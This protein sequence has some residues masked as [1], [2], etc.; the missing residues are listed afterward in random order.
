V[1]ELVRFSLPGGEK[2]VIAE[3][4]N[5]V[6]SP[7]EFSADNHWMT[8][9]RVDLSPRAGGRTI[10]LRRRQDH[11]VEW[12]AT[13]KND[14]LNWSVFDPFSRLMVLVDRA[15]VVYLFDLQA[16]KQVKAFNL[17]KNSIPWYPQFSPGGNRFAMISE[18]DD[19]I[20]V[21]GDDPNSY[22][23]SILWL[24]DLSKPTQPER[25][26]LPRNRAIRFLWTPDGKSLVVP[27]FGVLYVLDATNIA[28][29]TR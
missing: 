25:V 19:A 8:V 27:A 21:R 7:S 28:P 14:S 26:V 20:H 22:P 2:K 24:L 11:K 15:G 18:D 16:R 6:V 9:H 17:P 13:V 29:T 12:R 23:Q 1:G 5:A 10:E 4:A 3:E